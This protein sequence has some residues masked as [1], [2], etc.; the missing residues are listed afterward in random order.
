MT[1]GKLDQ[2]QE[3][4]P[5]EAS[6]DSS[7]EQA[8]RDEQSLRTSEVESAQH[9]TAL[10]KW[11]SGFIPKAVTVWLLLLLAFL[12]FDSITLHESALSCTFSDPS[13]YCRLFQSFDFDIDTYVMVAF[14]GSTSI[15]VGGLVNYA[16]RSLLGKT[17]E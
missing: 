6:N 7:K 14:V 4:K 17:Q 15:A 2:I 9:R 10:H 8:L 1:T 5:G 11:V 16:L 12:L 13:W 3:R